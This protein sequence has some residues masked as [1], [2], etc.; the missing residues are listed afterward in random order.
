MFGSR[1]GAVN[2]AAFQARSV[3]SRIAG[4]EFSF[5]YNR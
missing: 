3:N 4:K 1:A 5:L 2:L